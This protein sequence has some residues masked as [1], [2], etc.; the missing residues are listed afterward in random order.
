[1]EA[2]VPSRYIASLQAGTTAAGQN[3]AGTALDLVVRAVLPTEFSETR[4]RPVRFT[5]TN[6]DPSFAIGQP[7]TLEVPIG[8][9]RDV[10]V[11]PKDALVQARGGWTAFVNDGGKASPRTVT[12]GAALGDTFEVISGLAPGDE[13][14]VRGNERL[15]PGQDIAPMGGGGPPGAAS[16]GPPP[17]AESSDGE[18]EAEKG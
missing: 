14:V 5:L 1:V 17:V 18:T 7:V 2:N 12:I 13:V 6:I 4:T 10:L 3:D 11:V 8:S 16:G 9:A 15:R